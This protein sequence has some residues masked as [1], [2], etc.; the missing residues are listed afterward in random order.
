MVARIDTT[1]TSDRGAARS[2]MP[3]F[4]DRTVG[5]MGKFSDH[6]LGFCGDFLVWSLFVGLL[7]VTELVCFSV[8]LH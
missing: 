6:H 1:I 5:W 2:P 3:A 8:V 7:A 4:K